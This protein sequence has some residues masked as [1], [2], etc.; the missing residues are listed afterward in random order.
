MND[1]GLLL[2]L[3]ESEDEIE[4]IAVL[5]KHG[6]FKEANARRWVALGNMPNNQ[7]VVHAQQS[8]P[9][10]ALVEKFTNGL[11]AILLRRCKAQALDPRSI[12]APQSMSKAVYKWFGDLSEKTPQSRTQY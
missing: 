9:A 5:T 8:T 7:S 3:L 6:L 4:V 12:G 2:E 10:A 1:K 11:D